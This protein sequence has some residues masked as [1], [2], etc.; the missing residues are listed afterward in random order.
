MENNNSPSSDEAA[1]GQQKYQARLAKYREEQAKLQALLDERT[2]NNQRFSEQFSYSNNGNT[3][4]N[5]S[6]SQPFATEV[7]ISMPLVRQSQSTQSA[8]QYQFDDLDDGQ[9]MSRTVDQL[10]DA[11]K[12]DENDT[13]DFLHGFD[14]RDLKKLRETSEDIP[15][16]VESADGFCC[17]MCCMRSEFDRLDRFK[18]HLHDLHFPYPA[19]ILE[20]EKAEVINRCL[21]KKKS[22]QP[23]EPSTLQP[24]SAVMCSPIHFLRGRTLPIIRTLARPVAPIQPSPPDIAAATPTTIPTTLNPSD[25]Y[26]N[27]GRDK[28]RQL[29]RDKGLKQA[30]NTTE[31]LATLHQYDLL[32]KASGVLSRDSRVIGTHKRSSHGDSDNATEGEGSERMG[33]ARKTN[34]SSV[35]QVPMITVQKDGPL[36]H[37]KQCKAITFDAKISHLYFNREARTHILKVP[38]PP[39]MAKILQSVQP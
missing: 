31:L 11:V 17:D 22:V 8:A 36:W 5:R 21:Q 12:P 34:A 13:N 15:Q 2:R 37:N 33:K 23:A 9:L 20:K 25:D 19:G 32:G 28:L 14:D 38:V 24:M 18:K 7:P 26:A 1:K 29:C 35:K 4:R 16:I 27:L 10:A 3:A 39:P 30:G 6:N